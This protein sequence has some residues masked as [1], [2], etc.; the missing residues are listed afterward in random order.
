MIVA[1]GAAS[2]LSVDEAAWLL[3]KKPHPARQR[4]SKKASHRLRREAILMVL[5]FV[6]SWKALGFGYVLRE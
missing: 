6:L 3:P 5:S 2:S 1:S 4:M